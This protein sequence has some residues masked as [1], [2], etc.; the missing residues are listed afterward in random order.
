M[1]PRFRPLL[2]LK[3]KAYDL[4]KSIKS[5]YL[6]ERLK[7]KSQPLRA[8]KEAFLPCGKESKKRH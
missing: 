3:I 8:Q 5:R 6:E 4:K 7:I 2:I 1:S